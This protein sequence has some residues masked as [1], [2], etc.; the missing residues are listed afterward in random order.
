MTASKPC[1]GCAGAGTRPRARRLIDGDAPDPL[2]IVGR[3]PELCHDCA[4]SGRIPENPPART[5]KPPGR[6][7]DI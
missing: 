5:P 6:A 3:F 2:D 1:P 7:A 4:G